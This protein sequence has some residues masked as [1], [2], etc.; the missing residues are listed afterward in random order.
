MTDAELSRHYLAREESSS[1]TLVMEYLALVFGFIY[2]IVR[3][4]AEAED[5][6]QETF[7]KAWKKLRSYDREK[8]FKTWLFTIAKN[9][10]FDLLRKKKSAAFSDFDTELGEN[11]LEETIADQNPL[12]EELA[13]RAEKKG[14]LEGALAKLPL[15]YRTI[16]SLHYGEGFTFSEI[17]EILGKPLNTVKSQSRRALN[18]LQKFIP[19]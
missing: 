9:T 5:L 14:L 1:E 15:Q 12:P 18:T 4:R 11:L 17:S 6:T 13:I 8:N 3:D 7:V 19:A 16:I 2:R 10:A